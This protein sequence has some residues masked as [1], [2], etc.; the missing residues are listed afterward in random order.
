MSTQDAI[1]SNRGRAETGQVFTWA[2]RLRPRS[3]WDVV[4]HHLPLAVISGAALFLPYIIRLEKLPLRPCTFLHLTGYPCPLCGFTR[5]FWAIAE[6]DWGF[7][8]FNC[9]LSFAV[10]LF[11]AILFLWNASALIFR[12]VLSRGPLF[13]LNPVHRRRTI[14]IIILLFLLNWV[15]RLAM[16][17]K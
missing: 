14:D 8:L 4:V 5:S 3:Y 13:Q 10:Y 11:T 12:V 7:A 6:G 2:C 9:P 1:S 17:L 16:G 15:Y